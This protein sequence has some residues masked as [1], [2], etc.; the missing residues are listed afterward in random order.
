V[1]PFPLRIG[2]TEVLKLVAPLA[3]MHAADDDIEDD[4]DDDS[5][6]VE[7]VMLIALLDGE[8][9]PIGDECWPMDDVVPE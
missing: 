3:G 1:Q 5:I 9:E 4:L 8:E 2:Y 6:A 7:E